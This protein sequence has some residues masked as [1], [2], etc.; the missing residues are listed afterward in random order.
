[1]VSCYKCTATGCCGNC[2]CVKANRKCHGCLPSRQG[3]CRKS[4]ID[5]TSS[6][7]SL[8]SSSNSC[9]PMSSATSPLSLRSSLSV[10]SLALHRSSPGFTWG[11]KDEASFMQELDW[12]YSTIVHWKRNLFR[13]PSGNVGKP[14]VT[15]L[16]RLYDAFASIHLLK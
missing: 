3:H 5:R 6:P 11:T 14:F 7:S 1:M 9:P 12:A 10:S 13:V 15:E 8:T 2:A 4:D 16:T